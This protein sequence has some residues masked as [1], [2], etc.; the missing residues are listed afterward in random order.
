MKIYLGLICKAG[1]PRI[2]LNELLSHKIS[3]G[4]TFLLFGPI[5]ILI[6]LTAIHSLDDY[7]ERWLNPIS[8]IGEAEGLIVDTLTF[9]VG[10]EGPPIHQIPFAVVFVNTTPPQA[11]NVRRSILSIPEVLTADFVFGP[12]DIICPVRATDMADL[13]RVVL[14]LQT[15][16]SDIERTM[17][18][19]IKEVN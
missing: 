6:E 2:V 3:G 4:N 1:T 8:K 19:L 13:E 17:T 10:H 18:C 7:L 9:I 15:S 16:V 12:Y 5:D 14:T 11:E